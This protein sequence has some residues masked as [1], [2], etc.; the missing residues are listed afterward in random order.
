MIVPSSMPRLKG[1]RFPRE[2]IAYAVWVFH[3]FN[4]SAADIE[5]LLTER[6]VIVS[7]AAI[8]L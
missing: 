2:I 4:R 8:R 6:G 3:R 7:R 1:F 5:D